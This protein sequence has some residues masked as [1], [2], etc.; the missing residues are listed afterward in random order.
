ME[1]SLPKLGS[2]GRIHTVVAWTPVHS[3][4]D[5]PLLHLEIVRLEDNRRKNLVPLGFTSRPIIFSSPQELN[6]KAIEDDARYGEWNRVQLELDMQWYNIDEP[7]SCAFGDFYE[8]ESTAAVDETSQ[9]PSN[10]PARM[11]Q[12]RIYVW[13]ALLSCPNHMRHSLHF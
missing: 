6:G 1:G 4:E 8:S 11:I 7:G 12:A 13:I 2:E 5:L 10:L 9:G 3:P